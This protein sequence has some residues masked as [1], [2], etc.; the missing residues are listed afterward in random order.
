MVLDPKFDVFFLVVVVT[1]F[2]SNFREWYFNFFVCFC[3]PIWF[4]MVKKVNTRPNLRMQDEDGGR[5]G[6]SKVS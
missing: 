6:E 5:V 1:F 2:V 3:Y 4:L